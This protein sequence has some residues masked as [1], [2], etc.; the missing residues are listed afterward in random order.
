MIRDMNPEDMK[1]QAGEAAAQLIK[2][3]MIVGLGT[4]STAA[5]FIQALIQRIKEDDL[6]IKAAV[7]SSENSAKMAREGGISVMDINEVDH[8]DITVDGADE[9][10]SEKRLIKGAGGALLK[11]KILASSSSEM[12]VIID[13]TKLSSKL[14]SKKLPVEIVFFGSKQ[15]EAKIRK[16]GF[17]GDWRL[18]E[19]GSHYIT[20]NG[21]VI[22]DI[23]F[24]APLSNP[25]QDHQYL[26]EIPG[27]V[28]TGFF[29]NLASKIIVGHTDGN[30]EIL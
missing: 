10:D 7:A 6:K 23:A 14:G 21:N 30:I 18:Q 13:E 15:T 11:E 29:F 12:V 26:I 8:I 25:E 19:D 28:E 27:V 5:C 24:G 9:V 20:E 3:D 16:L 1:K 2:D 17:E 22:F 4:G